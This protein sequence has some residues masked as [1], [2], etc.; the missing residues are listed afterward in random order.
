MPPLSQMRSVALTVLALALVHSSAPAEFELS[1]GIAAV[2]NDSVITHEDVRQASAEA[3]ELYRRTYFNNPELFEQKRIAAM[4]EALEQ[5]IDKQLVLHDF[6]NLGGVL[7]ESYIDDAIKERIR[8]R[9]GDRVTLT[10][11]LQ[12]QHITYE[13]F[14]QRTRDEIITSIME[15]KYVREA[16][17]VSPAKI[18]RYY[19]TNLHRFK[20]G[21]QIKLRMI[22]LNRSP[23]ASADDIRQLASEIKSKIDEGAP[24]AEMATI[25]SE[26]SQRTQG[27]LWG[28]VEESKLKKGLSELAFALKPGQCSKVISLGNTGDGTY[29][30]YQYDP[31]GK[32]TVGRKFTERDAFL[33]EKAFPSVTGQEDLP[34]QPQEFYLLFVEERQVARTRL[35]Q[36]VRDEIEKDLLLQERARLQKKWIERLRTK[37]FV[38]IF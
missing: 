18:E 35:L 8:E 14:R 13:T 32:L 20:M 23:A 30:I 19:Q 33:E 28:W 37:S 15:K 27:G 34:A 25:Y 36:E 1:N 2:A 16:I 7:Q 5:L 3:V 38:V 9:F 31:S 29:W 12:A 6:K 11:T 21:D 4:S 26:G 10:K 17:L 24:F 22:V